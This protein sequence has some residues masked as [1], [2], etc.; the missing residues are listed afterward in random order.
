MSEEQQFVDEAPKKKASRKKAPKKN[1]V[2]AAIM[3]QYCTFYGTIGSGIQTMDGVPMEI[4]TDPDGR[5]V[6]VMFSSDGARAFLYLDQV[7]S[8]TTQPQ[9]PEQVQQGP[10]N[11]D[12]NQQVPGGSVGSEYHQPQQP[13][14]AVDEEWYNR[15]GQSTP[16]R[17]E[18][19][20]E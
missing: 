17:T 6:V 16:R 19:V 10:L 5:H 15:R 1:P 18:R 14:Q 3:G 8:F 11:F 4:V 20:S 12:M 9:V 7:A 13:G 2:A